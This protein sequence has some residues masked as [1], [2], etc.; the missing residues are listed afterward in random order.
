MDQCRKS[1]LFHNDCVDN[2]VYRVLCIHCMYNQIGAEKIH[3][4]RWPSAHRRIVKLFGA[5][6]NESDMG[7]REQSLGGKLH[8]VASE[9]IGVTANVFVRFLELRMQ[10]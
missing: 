6:V 4:D 5:A 10:S 2:Y 7:L 9:G 1:W 8:K 3:Q